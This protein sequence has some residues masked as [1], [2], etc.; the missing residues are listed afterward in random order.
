MHIKLNKQ[1]LTR[2]LDIVEKALPIRTAIPAIDNILFEC[3]EQALIFTATNM[4]IDIQVKLPHFGGDN[5]SILFPPKI[6]HIVRYLPETDVDLHFRRDDYRIEVNSGQTNYVLF[7]ADPAHYPIIQTETTTEHFLTFDQPLFKKVLK[8]TVFSA[9]TD[10]SR[11][12]FNGVLFHFNDN[13]LNIIA[14]DTY[15]LTMKN[16]EIEDELK[17]FTEKRSLVPAKSLRELLK[18]IGDEG[19][20]LI[21]PGTKQVI[22]KFDDIYFAA[23]ILEEKYPDISG[24]IP[25]KHITRM[26]TDKK[27]FEDTVSRASLLA[28]GI[29]QI[30]HFIIDES[31]LVVKV[32]SQI[33]KMEELVLG[34]Y[35]GDNVEVLVNSKF[36]L[37]ILKVMEQKEIMIDFHGKNGPLVFRAPGDP[38]YLYL[39]LP[40]KME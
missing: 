19:L 8:T 13:H 14:S 21:S 4:E 23:R 16:M 36:V 18:I 15:R 22:F 5:F 24:V 32:S 39:V 33:G 11:P 17:K 40:V 29:N 20:L 30:I 38:T 9:S 26:F 25:R 7:G 35:E 28:E 34:R 27:T 2:C 12:A 31:S 10:E 3:T 6:V 37:D 1:V